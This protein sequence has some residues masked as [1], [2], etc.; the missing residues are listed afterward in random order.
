MR[1]AIF[2]DFTLWKIQKNS[3]DLN[4]TTAES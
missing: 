2:W 4:Y 1:S 3:T